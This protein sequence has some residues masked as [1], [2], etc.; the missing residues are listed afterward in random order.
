MNGIFFYK[1]ILQKD[2]RCGLSE[3]TVNNVAAKKM[4]LKIIKYLFFPAN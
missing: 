1:R 3:K 2:M 4:D